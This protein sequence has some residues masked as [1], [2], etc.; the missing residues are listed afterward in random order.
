MIVFIKIIYLCSKDDFWHTLGITSWEDGRW[1]CRLRVEIQIWYPNTSTQNMPNPVAIGDFK[2][3]SVT[4]LGT[5]IS[6]LLSA[7]CYKTRHRN[8]GHI[9]NGAYIFR[10]VTYILYLPWTELWLL[11][12]ERWAWCSIKSIWSCIRLDLSEHCGYHWWPIPCANDMQT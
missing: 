3:S 5:K 9:F 8:H 1:G 4:R 10:K 12:S 11:G 7:A 2:H 6:D